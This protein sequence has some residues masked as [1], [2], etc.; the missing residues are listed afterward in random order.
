MFGALHFPAAT[1]SYLP[2]EV[3]SSD[4]HIIVLSKYVPTDRRAE[5]PLGEISSNTYIVSKLDHPV[6]W[7]YY[8]QYKAFRVKLS[9]PYKP[10]IKNRKLN[11]RD[12]GKEKKIVVQ[13]FEGTAP[14]RY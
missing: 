10:S 14:G 4:H 11:K 12:N 8:S 13:Y 3:Q 5:D 9:R 6:F 2:P 1:T 7:A